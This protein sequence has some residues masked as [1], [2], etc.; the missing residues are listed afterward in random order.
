MKTIPE[1]IEIFL[2]DN[3]LGKL[4]N[5]LA[6]ALKN[7]AIRDKRSELSLSNLTLWLSTAKCKSTMISRSSFVRRFVNYCNLNGFGNIP[8]PRNLDKK[9]QRKTNK[10]MEPLNLSPVA[11]ALERYIA[12]C[13]AAGAMGDTTHQCLRFFNDYCAKNNSEGKATVEEM[14]AG[15]CTKRNSESNSSFNKR[16]APIRSFIRYTN[17]V[18]Q[19]MLELPEYL[20]YE[21]KKF[22]PHPYT[23]EELQKLF[24]AADHL[25]TGSRYYGFQFKVR[26]LIIPVMLRLL[27]STGMRTCE[28]IKLSCKDVDLEYGVINIE[29]TK[30]Y[31]QHRIALH[32]SMWN[33]LRRYE[34]EISQLIPNRTAF[35]PNEFGNFLGRTWITYHFGNIWKQISDEPARVYDLRSNYAVAN[36]NSWKY[37]EHEWFDKLLYLSRTM[38]HSCVASTTYYYNLVPLFAEQLYEMTESDISEILPD[39]SDYYAFEKQ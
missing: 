13:R 37:T 17:R 7:W 21:K 32:Q 1:A 24:Y 30:G 36:I 4:H 8:I 28:L 9:E 25:S 38:G 33:L 6:S 39:L 34:D 11:D 14:V 18:N 3:T 15:W 31:D 27:Y 5:Y 23:K 26:K 19:S 20:P 2:Q 12:Y 35:F 10:E 16:I 22:I 29:K